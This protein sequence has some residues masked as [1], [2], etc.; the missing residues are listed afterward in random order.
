LPFSSAVIS[1]V[2]LAHVA[3]EWEAQCPANKYTV[4]STHVATEFAAQRPTVFSTIF[5]ANNSANFAA[6]WRPLRTAYSAT[7][8][9]AYVPAQ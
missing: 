8:R 2:G 7:F 9:V 5:S 1:A 6:Q 4:G 3:A